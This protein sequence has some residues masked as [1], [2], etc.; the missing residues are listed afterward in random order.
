MG[1]PKWVPIL[2][3]LQDSQYGCAGMST[4]FA[5]FAGFAIWVGLNEY[6]FC[7]FCRLCN[8]SP[9]NESGPPGKDGSLQAAPMGTVLRLPWQ[10]TM[11][12][13]ESRTWAHRV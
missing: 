9:P 1:R 3:M 6:P 5:H 4:H 11:E 10:S 12:C 8:M 7:S 13:A 2:L